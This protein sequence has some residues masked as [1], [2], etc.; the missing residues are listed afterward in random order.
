MSCA[1]DRQSENPLDFAETLYYCMPTFHAALPCPRS[2]DHM[3]VLDLSGSAPNPALLRHR[4]RVG[5]RAGNKT[6][7]FTIQM[8]FFHYLSR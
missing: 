3:I 5:P 6:N 1:T 8:Q 2:G 7:Q 4:D